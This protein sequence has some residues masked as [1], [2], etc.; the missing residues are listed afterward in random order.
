MIKNIEDIETINRGSITIVPKKPYYDWINYLA[1]E[2]PVSNNDFQEHN[3]YLVKDNFA[4]E[5][6]ENVVKKRFKIIFENELNEMWTE[7]KDW[8]Q[9]RDFRTFKNWF[10]F[11]ISSLVMDLENSE[12][13]KQEF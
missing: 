1:P 4:P 10:N 13:I 3:S 2:N 8:P 12:V 7:S 11:H 5:N 9:K 6:L